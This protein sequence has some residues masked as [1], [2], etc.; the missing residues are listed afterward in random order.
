MGQNR[1]ALGTASREG[2]LD[3][4]KFLLDRGVDANVTG[5]DYGTALGAAASRGK[6]GIAKLL[7]DRGADVNLPNGNCGT[8]LAT[9]AWG[10]DFMW[11]DCWGWEDYWEAS[12]ELEVVT[13][14]LDRGASVN[15]TGSECG[16]ALGVASYWSKLDTVALLLDRPGH[17]TRCLET[18]W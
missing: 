10:G 13:L 15:L 6:L 9:A 16:T 18:A 1:T 8:A 11:I 2:H 5:G 3:I 12:R 14:L 7:L 17:E 4:V